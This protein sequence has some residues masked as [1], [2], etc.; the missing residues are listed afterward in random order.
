MPDTGDTKLSNLMDTGSLDTGDL[1]YAVVQPFDTGSGRRVQLGNLITS[2]PGSA[3][4]DTG[5]FLSDTGQFLSDTGFALSDTGRFLSDSGFALSDTGFALSDTGQFL[6]DTGFALSD[7]GFALSDTGFALSDTGQFLSDTGR[8]LSDSGF[9]A[10]STAATSTLAFRGTSGM[11][12][13]AQSTDTGLSYLVGADSAPTTNISPQFIMYGKGHASWPGEAFFTAVTAN[14]V[15]KGRPGNLN[16][17]SQVVVRRYFMAGVRTN[18]VLDT[19]GWDA[20]GVP[21]ADAPIHV[22]TPTGSLGD[23]PQVPGVGANATYNPTVVIEGN[24]SGGTY[25]STQYLCNDSGIYTDVHGNPD[26]SRQFFNEY[27]HGTGIAQLQAAN[28]VNAPN[29]VLAYDYQDVFMAGKTTRNTGVV[30]YEMRGNGSAHFTADGTYPLYLNRLTDDGVLIH[31][32]QANTIEGNIDVV[33]TTVALNGAHL[34]RWTQMSD[35]TRL[36]RGTLVSTVNEMVEWRGLKYFDYEK[37]ENVVT[38]SSLPKD[39]YENDTGNILIYVTEMGFER[40]AKIVSLPNEQLTKSILCDTK[41]DPLI[42]GVV[43]HY[44]ED[45]DLVIAE[46]GDFIIRIHGDYT[47]KSGDLVASYRKGCAY[48]QGDAVVRSH[49]VAK[50]LSDHKTEIYEDGSYTVPCL[51]KL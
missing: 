20:N 8:F 34:A 1:I 31:F 21:V 2:F 49:T 27:N 3:Q 41:D 44:D 39:V 40:T 38:E 6:S 11:V 37:Q 9:D 10:S 25:F 50:V 46:V 33:G 26:N 23:D 29:T 51:L 43:D 48:P 16:F 12:V 17:E 14:I 5:Y 13:K 42:S 32:A 47:V 22:F 7:T 28:G 15:S 18:L 45:G 30:G 19:G 35:D 24:V 4:Q 36:P